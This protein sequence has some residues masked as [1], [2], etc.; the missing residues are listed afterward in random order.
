MEGAGFGWRG[1]TTANW[2]MKT[3]KAE[4]RRF[5]KQQNG[6]FTYTC[7]LL[8]TMLH[9]V[10]NRFTLMRLFIPVT[11]QKLKHRVWSWPRWQYV[12]GK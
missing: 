8:K 12:R 7:I 3:G 1:C 9:D 10:I 11:N 2:A 5:K 6:K 4:E